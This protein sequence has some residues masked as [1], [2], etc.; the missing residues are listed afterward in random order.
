MQVLCGPIITRE[1]LKMESNRICR[2]AHAGLDALTFPAY[3]TFE[4]S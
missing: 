3:E 2:A 4:V 1:E